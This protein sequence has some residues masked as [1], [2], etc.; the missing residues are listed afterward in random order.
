MDNN[1]V[2]EIISKYISC[3]NVRV[4]PDSITAELNGIPSLNTLKQIQVDFNAK[5]IDLY[6]SAYTGCPTCGPEIETEMTIKL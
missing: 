1:K 6:C 5:D 4:G 2:M 3:N